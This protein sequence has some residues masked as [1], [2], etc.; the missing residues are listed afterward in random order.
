MHGTDDK[1][2]PYENVVRFKQVMKQA[3]NECTLKSYKKQ[4]HGFF[5]FSREPKYFYKT[6]KA[7]EAFLEDLD[8][9]KGESWIKLYYKDLKKKV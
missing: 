2:V 8:V 7:T 9:L 5:N 3:G 4:G 6:L 1:T